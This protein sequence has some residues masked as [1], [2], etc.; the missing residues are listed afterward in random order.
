MDYV[1]GRRGPDRDLLAA[2]GFD[3]VS[4]RSTSSAIGRRPR[5]LGRLASEAQR[6]R[7]RL[8]AA[9]SRRSPTR[10][11]R[12]SSTRWPIPTWSR[13][14][15]AGGPARERDPRFYYEPAV[16]AIA[17]AGVAVEVS[18]AGLAQAGRGDLP[19]DRASP[20]CCVDAGVP[21]ALSSDAHAPPTS[22]TPTS[23]P[24][25]HAGLG[26]EEICVFERPRSRTHG[27]ARM[28]ARVGIG[29]DSHRF[30]PGRRLIIGGVEIDHRAG[31]RRPLR[32]RRAHPRDHRRHPRRRRR[33]A[34]SATH[35]PPTTSAGGTPTRRPAA[36]SCSRLVRGR[37]VNVDAT[38]ICEAP[39]LGPHR[40]A[41]ER[42]LAAAIGAPV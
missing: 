25:R 18:T 28:S 31:P 38:V 39:P 20:S 6:S 17:E 36:R 32:R 42:G 34:T 35:F 40:E 30:A 33:S 19:G 41:M 4:A 10:P 23:R 7:R 15:A 26:I 11:G 37:V 2:R 14:G 9:T 24:W 16:E 27:A 12:A 8:G 3:Y 29:Y 13:S 5:R 22:A 1:A 21:F